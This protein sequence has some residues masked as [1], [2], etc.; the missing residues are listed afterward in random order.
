MPG[1]R[2]LGNPQTDW[3]ESVRL[4]TAAPLPAYGGSGTAI[5]TA[6]ANGALVVDGA[7]VVGNNR[8]LVKNE[9]G[10]THIDNRIWEV[11]QVGTPN[12]GGTPWIL[13][14]ASDFNESDEVTY[15]YTVQVA[16]GTQADTA[17]RITTPDPITPGTTAITW[18]QSAAPG[19]PLSRQTLAADSLLD[20][21][22]I[23]P[24]TEAAHTALTFTAASALLQTARRT[25]RW[26]AMLNPPAA[27]GADTW[28]TRVRL[29]AAGVGG[30]LLVDSTAWDLVTNAGLYI[31]GT[32]QIMTVG[33]GGTFTSHTRLVRE[34]GGVVIESF[35]ASGAL[36]TTVNRNLTVTGESST[37]NANQMTLRHLEAEVLG[38]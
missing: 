10:G 28:R 3:N 34:T 18:A 27:V 30:V 25:I 17:W 1:D 15:G 2:I 37:N 36:D 8:V 12:P 33:A 38:A 7:A 21:S 31:E 9:G 26:R 13:R 32:I 19:A 23:G 29:G 4:A 22:I 16:A 5:L 35:V 20:G 14:A 24:A 11:Q 6:A